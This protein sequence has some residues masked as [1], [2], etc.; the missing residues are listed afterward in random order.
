MYL[1]IFLD[2]FTIKVEPDGFICYH[3]M[4]LY[5]VLL[6]IRLLCDTSI[7]EPCMTRQVSNIIFIDS[8]NI[9][10]RLYNFYDSSL[11]Y[12]SIK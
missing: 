2:K 4:L 11:H 5:H 9:C 3:Y 10:K 1:F 12:D 8:L 6:V 7:G